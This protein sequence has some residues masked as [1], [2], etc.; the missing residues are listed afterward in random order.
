MERYCVYSGL[1]CGG[2]QCMEGYRANS[3]VQCE[4]VLCAL[5]G[6][7]CVYTG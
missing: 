4:E 5:R 2:D 3:G 1:L 6:T 7:V